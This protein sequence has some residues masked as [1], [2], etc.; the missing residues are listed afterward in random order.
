LYLAAGSN[1]TD[2]AL[3]ILALSS[4]AVHKRS[5]R[6]LVEMVGEFLSGASR[7]IY[8][9]RTVSVLLVSSEYTCV[10]NTKDS[11]FHVISTRTWFAN[12]TD[13]ST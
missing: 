3:P 2:S 7:R 5:Q 13:E 6:W 1:A 8:A 11:Q 4:L 10:L 9:L 12:S